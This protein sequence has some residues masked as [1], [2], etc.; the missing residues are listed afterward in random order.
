M[1]FLANEWFKV[2]GLLVSAC[3]SAAPAAQTLVS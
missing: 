2:A 3:K 1:K